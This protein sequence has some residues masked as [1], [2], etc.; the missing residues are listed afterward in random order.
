MAPGREKIRLY[1]M[2]IEMQT[3]GKV[4]PRD[5]EGSREKNGV[6]E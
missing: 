2:A 1:E 4:R 6:L 5:N 3:A